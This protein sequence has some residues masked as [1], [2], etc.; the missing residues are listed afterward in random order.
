M[1]DQSQIDQLQLEEAIVNGLNN[2]YDYDSANYDYW[3]SELYDNQHEPILSEWNEDN[4]RK[5]ETDVMEAFG[6]F[7]N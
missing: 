7:T 4:L 6:S 5:I 3:V 1:L 2:L